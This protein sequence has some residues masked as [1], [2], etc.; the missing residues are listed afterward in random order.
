LPPLAT[1]NCRRFSGPLAAARKKS[2]VVLDFKGPKYRIR[3][4]R[5]AASAHRVTA[6][7]ESPFFTAPHPRSSVQLVRQRIRILIA[8]HAYSRV[9]PRPTRRARYWDVH[10]AWRLNRSACLHRGPSR[11]GYRSSLQSRSAKCQHADRYP[12]PHRCVF[13]PRP[14]TFGWFEA[15][16]L[17]APPPRQHFH[18]RSRIRCQQL[19]LNSSARSNGGLLASD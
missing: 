2:N 15:C 4:R 12:L 7:H 5:I 17:L 8:A 6:R 18:R 9:Q 1:T 14:R 10:D 11:S 16:V 3:L 19:D 13:C